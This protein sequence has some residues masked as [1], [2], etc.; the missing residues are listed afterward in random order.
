M[1]AVADTAEA[2]AEG[3]PWEWERAQLYRL[4]RCL[5]LLEDAH[6]RD[7]VVLSVHLAD[8][9]R[10]VLPGI[11]AGS[12]IGHVI[13]R[14]FGEQEAFLPRRQPGLGPGWADP[15]ELDLDD[16]HETGAL[17][18]SRAAD[19]TQ[20]IRSGTHTVCLL[21]LEAHEGRAWTVLGYPSWERY[22]RQEFD[23]SRRRAYEL[24]DQGRVVRTLQA[25]SGLSGPPSISAYAAC[26]IK[27][28]LDQ[29]AETV[30]RRCAGQPEDRRVEIVQQVVADMRRLVN[31]RPDRQAAN[32]H[33]EDHEAAE[34]HTATP[35]RAS[36]E[37]AVDR[38]LRAIEALTDLPS[39]EAACA[40]IP[41][42]QRQRLAELDGV[43]AWLAEFTRLV[44]RSSLV[45]AEPAAYAMSG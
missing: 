15:A 31:A 38:L 4:D 24:V 20:R 35:A 32:G 12:L 14:V 29:V 36:P 43:V 25:S 44:R 40:A 2:G 7:E 34:E 39:P 26:Q 27:A 3:A 16:E 5:D 8:E 37:P 18:R 42:E 30:R 11:A 21:M 6:E 45:V 22:V 17:D 41:R 1:I 33:P 13:D 10:P 23:L 9:L 28:H 19:L